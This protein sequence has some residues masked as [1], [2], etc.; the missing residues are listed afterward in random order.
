MANDLNK[1]A[2][3]RKKEIDEKCKEE[4]LKKAELLKKLKKIIIKND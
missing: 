1:K 2:E 3:K 4:E